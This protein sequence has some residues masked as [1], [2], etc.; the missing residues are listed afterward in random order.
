[1]A[2]EG[3]SEPDE[4]GKVVPEVRGVHFAYVA[5]VSR[6]RCMSKVMEACQCFIATTI[7]L[8]F[9]PLKVLFHNYSNRRGLHFSH[10][11]VI[12]QFQFRF[13]FQIT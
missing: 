10:L 2:P 13:K 5:F 1:M 6:N 11:T 3:L 9:Y 12:P 7:I 8:A 4:K